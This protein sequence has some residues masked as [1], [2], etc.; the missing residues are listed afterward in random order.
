MGGAMPGV[1]GGDDVGVEKTLEQGDAAS[2]SII[3]TSS[4]SKTVLAIDP[5][6]APSPP[7]LLKGLGGCGPGLTFESEAVGGGSICR[8]DIWVDA[9]RRV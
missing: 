4:C 5:L 1:V 8:G 2:T 3:S 9:R 7:P 6:N